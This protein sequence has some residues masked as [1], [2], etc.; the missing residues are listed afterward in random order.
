MMPADFLTL[1]AAT[2]IAQ[3][4]GSE[5]ALSVTATVV[6]PVQISAPAVDSQGSVVTIRNTAGIEVRA[7]GATVRR[8][9]PETVTVT[10]DG[11]GSMAIIIVY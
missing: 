4:S 5:A 1:I 11:T 8:I 7:E 9:G 2:A 10:G 3:A 6:R